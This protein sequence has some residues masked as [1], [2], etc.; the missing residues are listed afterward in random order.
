MASLREQIARLLT[1]GL[2]ITFLDALKLVANRQNATDDEIDALIAL[3]DHPIVTDG[4]R[5]VLGG[6]LR[7]HARQ[8]AEQRDEAS[9]TLTLS[10]SG[11]TL[12]IQRGQRIALALETRAHLGGVWE[13]A[14]TD[15]QL[16]TSG[17]DGERRNT[18]ATLEARRLGTFEVTLHETLA[19]PVKNQP[20]SQAPKQDAR[21]FVLTLIVER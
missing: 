8:R 11:K 16:L 3:H 15:V 1:T 5:D 14:S 19:P 18:H 21:S 20:R 17:L 12:R 9:K 4:A 10:D 2:P 6:L 13:S 7:K